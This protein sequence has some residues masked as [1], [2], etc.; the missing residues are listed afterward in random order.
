MT[1]KAT[2][3][4]RCI[5]QS[6][7][8]SA[9]PPIRPSARPSTH[10][11]GRPTARPPAHPSARPLVRPSARPLGAPARLSARASV[12]PPAHPSARPSVCPSIHL[13]PTLSRHADRE[14]FLQSTELAAVAAEGRDLTLLL[15]RTVVVHSLRDAAAE[16]T[17]KPERT[18]VRLTLGLTNP[19]T[20]GRQ[21]SD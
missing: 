20:S 11:P 2:L 7:H 19:E 4:T 17:L 12:R 13:S 6:V 15:V 16:E 5:C 18:A 21:R 1:Y 9:R 14:T 3:L 10:P 8:P